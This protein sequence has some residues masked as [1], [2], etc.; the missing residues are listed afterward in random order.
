[1]L[2]FRLPYTHHRLLFRGRLYVCDRRIIILNCCGSILTGCRLRN[3]L[4]GCILTV[5]AT[6]LP[7]LTLT[8]FCRAFA[9][10]VPVLG[11]VI[12]SGF[13]RSLLIRLLLA[14]RSR[15]AALAAGAFATAAFAAFTALAGLAFTLFPGLILAGFLV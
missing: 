13:N 5:T 8:L 12:C 3:F 1:M 4:L 10:L 2:W 9:G 15:L 7:G 11:G 14:C 6:T